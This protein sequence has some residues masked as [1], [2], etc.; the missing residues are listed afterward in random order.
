MY[1]FY[2]GNRQGGTIR[3]VED[4]NDSVIEGSYADY[5]TAGDFSTEFTFSHF[6]EDRCS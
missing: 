4:P 1:C 3:E 2:V 5:M 6:D